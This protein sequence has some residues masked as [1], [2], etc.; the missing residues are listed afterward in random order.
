MFPT[1]T[2]PSATGPAAGQHATALPPE[3][4]QAGIRHLVEGVGG[5]E[6]ASAATDPG[7]DEL[8]VEAGGV[9]CDGTHRRAFAGGAC[10]VD[11]D[12]RVERRDVV[13]RHGVVRGRHDEGAPSVHCGQRGDA[14][15]DGVEDAERAGHGEEVVGPVAGRDE[16]GRLGSPQ[17]RGR[18]VAL[19]PA[20]AHDDLVERQPLRPP[21][22]FEAGL[23]RALV[24]PAEAEPAQRLDA[25]GQAEQVGE[26]G[27]LEEGDPTETETVGAGREPD[28]LDGG[29]ARP[30]V[31][32][33]EGRATE[34]PG[35]RRAAVTRDDDADGRLADALEAQVEQAARGLLGHPGGLT[36]SA[37]VG[38]QRRGV[39]RR[40]LGDDDEAPRLTVPDR[41]PAVAGREHR[42]QHVG[43]HRVG[44][45]ATDVAARADDPLERGEVVAQGPR[46]GR[47]R[48][49]RR[50]M[51][52]RRS[53]GQAC[54]S[55]RSRP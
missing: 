46:V 47:L 24:G 21:G 13:C 5:H 8:D 45:E 23:G 55:S 28:V 34:H 49:A 38:H 25:V 42:G 54:G 29:G 50:P 31:G 3:S 26:L 2:S 30:E 27:R 9:G 15:E 35:G 52:G 33:G 22:A 6:I 51:S 37:A 12:R 44:S 20:L 19:G 16:V 14:V 41:R 48:P 18:G 4:Q 7:V 1:P 32:V 36:Q 40:G 53:W 11:G 39:P 10:H 43:R 17:V